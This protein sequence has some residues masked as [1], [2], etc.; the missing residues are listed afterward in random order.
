MQRVHGVIE[1]RNQNLYGS[2]SNIDRL[3]LTVLITE[4]KSK[5]GSRTKIDKSLDL[6]FLKIFFGLTSLYFSTLGAMEFRT[7]VERR[8]EELRSKP[9]NSEQTWLI[10]QPSK[11]SGGDTRDFNKGNLV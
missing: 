10:P 1:V 8:W 7:I 5:E 6:T 3:Y 2:E 11:N 9:F 4:F